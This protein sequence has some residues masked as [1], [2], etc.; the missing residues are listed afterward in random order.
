MY[1]EQCLE[2]RR[3]LYFVQWIQGVW[4]F[5]PIII[6]PAFKHLMETLCK[7]FNYL[8]HL[9]CPPMVWVKRWHWLF[10]TIK[11]LFLCIYNLIELRFEPRSIIPQCQVP[12]R[13]NAFVRTSEENWPIVLYLWVTLLYHLTSL[14]ISNNL[15]PKQQRF[16]GNQYT[17]DFC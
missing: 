11:L 14:S 10:I 17:S 4:I 7:H 16:S 5:M 13:F 6:G 9:C 2:H 1:L 15:A 8:Y 3:C 12:Y